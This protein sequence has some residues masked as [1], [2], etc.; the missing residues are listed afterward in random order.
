M[1]NDNNHNRDI[2]GNLLEEP[3]TIQNEIIQEE[4]ENEKI[5]L[6]I[7]IIGW[8]IAILIIGL[9]LSIIVFIFCSLFEGVSL[10]GI[11]IIIGFIGSIPTLLL[12]GKI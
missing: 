8:V 7:K 10:F 3:Q 6:P 1:N 2:L 9:V 4:N 5:S 12:K 11:I